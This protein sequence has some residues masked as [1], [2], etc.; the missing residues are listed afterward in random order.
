MHPFLTTEAEQIAAVMKDVMF[1]INLRIEDTRRQ[2][3]DGLR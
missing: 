3:Y 1:R 2:C